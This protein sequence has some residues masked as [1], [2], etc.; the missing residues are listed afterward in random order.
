MVIALAK[1]LGCPAVLGTC[2]SSPDKYASSAV[3]SSTSSLEL[4]F[5]EKKGDKDEERHDNELRRL[6]RYHC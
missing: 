4:L 2:S 3:D 5:L 1:Q 6:R